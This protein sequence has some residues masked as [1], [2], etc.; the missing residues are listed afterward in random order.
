MVG[1]VVWAD[2]GLMD[3]SLDSCKVLTGLGS[4]APEVQL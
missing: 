3:S 1:C 4:S 2:H